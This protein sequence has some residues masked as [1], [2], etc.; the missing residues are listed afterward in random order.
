MDE[1]IEPMG[2]ATLVQFMKQKI[3]IFKESPQ[4]PTSKDMPRLVKDPRLTLITRSPMT[5]L[6]GY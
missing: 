1:Q 4:I 3:V 5:P 6:N 2:E